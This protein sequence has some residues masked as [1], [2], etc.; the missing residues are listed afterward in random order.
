MLG[1]GALCR[2]D[3]PRLVRSTLAGS[4]QRPLDWNAVVYLL[5]LLGEGASLDGALRTVIDDDSAAIIMEI[6]GHQTFECFRRYDKISDEDL[7][8]AVAA[9]L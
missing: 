8:T 7:K 2:P 1:R 9:V 4:P 3:L 6:T 5:Q